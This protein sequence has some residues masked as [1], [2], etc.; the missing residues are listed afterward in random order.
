MNDADHRTP[1]ARIE[2]DDRLVVL[3]RT[4]DATDPEAQSALKDGVVN[5]ARFGETCLGQAL[6]RHGT[7]YRNAS[8]APVW[9][10]TELSYFHNLVPVK[11]IRDL[12]VGSQ[13]AG[14][15]LF[16][17]EILATT[18]S[19]FILPRHL[20]SSADRPDR[21]ASLEFINVD[22]AYLD[23]YRE[24]MRDFCGPAAE[25]LVRANRFGSFRAMETIAVLF[26]AQELKIDWNQIHLCELDPDDFDGFGPE[27]EATL[28]E[29]SPDR[30]DLA[31]TFA[32][33]DRMR[34][35]PRWT[36]NDPIVEVDAAL[37][38]VGTTGPRLPHR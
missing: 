9:S 27:F 14:T 20:Q 11:A 12:V 23:A 32:R 35:I 22:T 5:W 16:R 6:Y 3:A 37:G 28:R 10:H 30:T 15:R 1:L 7:V 17:A 18:P 25:R 21:Q 31:G 34:T 29:A 19:S 38:R 4:M 33:L 13:P 36:Y 8:E 2:P 26:Q 24:A